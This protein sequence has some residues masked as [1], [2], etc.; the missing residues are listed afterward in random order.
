VT[1][2][3]AVRR[4]V[5]A[6]TAALLWWAGSAAAALPAFEAC[7]GP[8]GPPRS[9]DEL[10]CLYRVGLQHEA[11]AEARAHLRRLGAGGPARPWHTL[12]LAHASVDA[13]EGRA[14]AL[15][16]AAAEGFTRQGEPEGEVLARHNLRVLHHRRGNAAGAE[17]QVIR[18]RAVGASST[19]PLVVARAAVLEA[20]HLIETGGDIGEAHRALLRAREAAFPGGPI[21]LRRTILFHL[22]N[23]CLYLGRLDEAIEALEQHR[24]LRREDGAPI[25][26]AR[27]AFNL[28]TARL[29]R[30]EERPVP[31]ARERVLEAAFDTLREAES[32]GDAA[33]LARTHNVLGDLLRTRD[34]ERAAVHLGRCL[35]AATPLGHAELRAPCL[36][37]L[38]RHEAARHPARAERRSA[39]AVALLSAGNSGS[40]LAHAWQARLRLVWETLAENDA[41]AASL[42]ALRAIERLRANQ[43]DD[44]SRATLF[45][46]WTRDYHWLTGRLLESRP[47]RLAEAFEVGERLRARVLLESLER[48]GVRATPPAPGG[49]A[50]LAAVTTAFASLQE[51]QR[52]LGERE[53]LLWF[54]VAPWEDLYGDF[55]GGSWLLSVTR[56]TVGLHRLPAR[57]Q[58]ES[59]VP[60][61]VGLLRERGTPEHLWA[62]GASALGAALLGP[63][64]AALPPAVDRLVIVSEGVLHRLPFEALRPATRGPALG[65]RFDVTV[66]PSA[67]LWLQL[68][69]QRKP[70]AGSLLV[71]AD[72]E[73]ARGRPTGDL[74]LGPLPWA[75]REARAIRRS[76]DLPPERLREGPA[77]SEHFV[78]SGIL[79][80]SAVVHFAAHARADDTFPERSAVFL[81]P[82]SPDEDGWL[83]PN[84]I[85]ALDLGGQLVVLS[86]CESAD[87][88]LLSGEGPLSLARAFF[89]A[90]AGAVVATRWPLRDDDAAFLMERFYEGL[91]GGA[92]IGE[93]LRGARRD[94][95]SSRRPAAAWSGVVLLGDG[96]SRPFAALGDSGGREAPSLPAR[97]AASLL[98][99]L[100][101]AVAI[102]RLRPPR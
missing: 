34:P 95:V 102:R 86:A 14:L 54:S 68:R 75:R 8:E 2:A 67:T 78:K 43:K 70:R 92:N 57:T 65:E 31:G 63:A 35:D 82:G 12:V 50:G 90:G 5:G 40:L 45:A 10:M 47:P 89:A 15:Y 28:L 41:I 84:E 99:A 101:A 21:G 87:G 52:S 72:P 94:A 61:L 51:V 4:P 39:E 93:A 18:A 37:T 32:L 42:E 73:L 60:A 11:L 6:V 29:T 98:L 48:A 22:A 26:A 20:S 81:A 9:Y 58:L 91:A 64:V 79:R 76:V 77:A 46:N 85:A 49:D 44:V 36:W 25:D 74:H 19:R 96:T 33:V 69:R 38:A 24:A 30:A 97:L 23:A 56:S 80:G 7:R 17:R 66:A 59:Q 16:E 55:G 3:A 83:Q 88:A 53:A 100:G 1:F 27:V 71:L 13:D 62:P